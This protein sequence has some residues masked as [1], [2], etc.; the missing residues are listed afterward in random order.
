MAPIISDQPL[1]RRGESG[2]QTRAVNAAAGV[3]LAAMKRGRQIPTSLAVDLDCAGLLNSPETAAELAH[4]RAEM[5]ALQDRVAEL[6]RLLGTKARTVD[7]DPIRFTLTD[8]AEQL[9]ATPRVRALRELVDRQRAQ[10]DVGGVTHTRAVQLEDPHD[11]PLHHDYR[12]G[13]DLPEVTR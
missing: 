1:P 8:K 2:M 10:T 11:S 3:L 4:L 9:P 13:R 12:L 6:E 7:E 5:P